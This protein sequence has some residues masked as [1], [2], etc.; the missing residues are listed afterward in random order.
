VAKVSAHYLID[1][2]GTVVA[3]VSDELRAWHA[4]VS[5]WQGRAG[6]NDVSLG[7]EL[8]NPGHEWGYR[9]FPE[10]QTAALIDLASILAERWRIPP[11]RVVGHSDIAPARKEDPGELLD[12]AR[13]AEAGL[14][15][16]V[17][18]AHPEEPDAAAASSA[19]AHIGYAGD[20]QGV[21]FAAALRAFQRRWRPARC[22]GVLDPE[23]MGLVLAVARLRGDEPG[24][25]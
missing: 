8:V 1:E 5:W 25:T 17:A 21:P 22:D 14:C 23:S 13:L 12:W 6:L 9:P 19:L 4:G 11:T 16:S 7:I 20:A 24:A 10:P 2:D 3:L 18:A 15:L